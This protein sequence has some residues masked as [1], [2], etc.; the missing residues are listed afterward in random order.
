MIK[1]IVRAALAVLALYVAWLAYS[2]LS[3]RRYENPDGAAAA[4]ASPNPG[5]GVTRELQ[6]VYHIHTTFSDGHATVD[7]VAARAAREHLDFVILTDH[8]NPNAASLRAA[9]PR[10][11]VLVLAGSELNVNRGHLV[12]LGFRPPPGDGKLPSK[13]EDAVAA[14]RALG[15]FTVI[16]HPYSKV[17][18]SWGDWGES[19]DYSGIEIV[20]ADTMFKDNYRRVLAYA[21]LLLLGSRLPLIKMLEHPAS[22]LK[23]WDQRGANAAISGYFS[24]D[25]HL[26]YRGIF[27]LLRLH[28]LLDGPAGAGG[29]GPGAEAALIWDALHHGHFYNAVEAVADAR[30]FRFEAETAAGKGAGSGPG[31]ARAYRMGD[32]IAAAGGATRAVRFEARAPFSFRKEV[33]L[34]R[35]G[36]VIAS[37]REDILRAPSEGP[38]V[39]RVEVYLKERSALGADIP[40]IVSNPIYLRKE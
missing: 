22:N 4:A 16:A 9:G 3:F 17:R 25:A 32:T 29:K 26:Y 13:A 1:K 20:N 31:S 37:S 35:D 23:R 34:L 27:A 10:K 36:R 6:G 38:G 39:Y 28:V 2:D 14:V 19:S 12:A 11:G 24:A 18:W 5:G 40:W 33:R 7:E 30:G 8:G 15:G 21:P